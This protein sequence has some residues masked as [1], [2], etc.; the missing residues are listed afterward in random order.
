MG[1]AW[2]RYN[3]PVISHAGPG[4]R[5]CGHCPKSE[6]ARIAVRVQTGLER[7]R[8]QGKRLGRPCPSMVPLERLAAVEGTAAEASGPTSWAS[9]STTLKWWKRNASTSEAL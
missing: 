8:R 7:A 3:G 5:S 2:V 6:R 4:G 9:R 1:R